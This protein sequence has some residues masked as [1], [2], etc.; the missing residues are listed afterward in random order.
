MSVITWMGIKWIMEWRERETDTWHP[1]HSKRQRS[2]KSWEKS[3]KARGRRI[4][5]NVSV[6][7]YM[8][9]LYENQRRGDCFVSRKHD[10]FL[11]RRALE[12]NE[13]LSHLFRTSTKREHVEQSFNFPSIESHAEKRIIEQP[14][15][16]KGIKIVTPRNKL[17]CDWKYMAFQGNIP[18]GRGREGDC[19][20]LWLS[21]VST[22]TFT[23]RIVN[24]I[25]FVLTVGLFLS[26]SWSEW[27]DSPHV[28]RLWILTIST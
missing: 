17:I 9:C 12:L 4:I 5:F 13:E 20:Y 27:V 7:V 26:L 16:K 21:D 8:Y 28:S 22:L 24:P 6:T 19:R 18:R 10:R 14:S 25:V 1:T 23:I 2:Q 3:K 15:K 11:F